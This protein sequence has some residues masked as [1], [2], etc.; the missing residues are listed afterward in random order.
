MNKPDILPM[1][2]GSPAS[3]DQVVHAPSAFVQQPV[4]T[5]V[6]NSRAAILPTRPAQQAATPEYTDPYLFETGYYA[7]L[8]EQQELARTTAARLQLRAEV[9]H[10]RPKRQ[11]P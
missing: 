3:S 6:A 2:P 7:S 8:A 9:E 1:L 4:S 5:K 11:K 10:A